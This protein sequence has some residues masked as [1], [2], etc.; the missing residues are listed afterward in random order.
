MGLTGPPIAAPDDF[1]VTWLEPKDA[2]RTWHQERT[3]CPDSTTLLGMD[4]CEVVFDCISLTEERFGSPMRL[5][6]RR[7]QHVVYFTEHMAVDP[8]QVEAAKQESK[9]VQQALA[10]TLRNLWQDDGHGQRLLGTEPSEQG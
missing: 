3:H 1:P 4:F 2:E 8:E 10:P 9:E 5:Q 7:H 6:L